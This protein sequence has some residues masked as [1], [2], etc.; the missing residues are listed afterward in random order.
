MSTK[1]AAKTTPKIILGKRPA[2]F[3]G[4]PVKFVGPDGS[5]M[6]IPNVV[7][8]YRSRAEYSAFVDALQGA[9]AYVPEPGEK[10]SNQKFFAAIGASN[11]AALL[12]CISSW[13]L[14]VA[15]DAETLEQLQDEMPAATLALWA[16]YG[17]AARDGRLGN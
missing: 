15:V 9:E 5:D 12:D 4:F 11:V 7:F 3:A 2:A 1:T 8:K 17:N 14:D 10:F 6:V 13:G 16:A